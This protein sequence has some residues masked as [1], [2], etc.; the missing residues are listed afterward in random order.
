[1]D[2]WKIWWGAFRFHYASASFPARDF[3]WNDCLTADRQF[4]PGYFLL[5]ML[6][7]IL[8]HL[9]LN[10]TDD[11]YDFQHLVNIFATRGEILT[12]GAVERFPQVSSDP[13]HMRQVFIAFYLIAIAIGLFLGVTRGPLV[14]LALHTVV[15]VPSF[16]RLPLLNSVIEELGKLL[17]SLFWPRNWP[18]SVLR[19]NSEDLLGRTLDE[20]RFGIMLFSMITINE[21]PDYLEDREAGKLNLVA[22][23]GREAGS[24]YSRRILALLTVRYWSG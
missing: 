18:W 22:R 11:Y 23:F 10:M 7:L 13:K 2:R 3:G 21:I 17:I 19:S 12:P 5:V 8:N 1:M 4:H 9:A 15:S 20:L 6:G 24:G 14:L 16:T